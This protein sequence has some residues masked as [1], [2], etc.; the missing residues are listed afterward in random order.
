MSSNTMRHPLEKPGSNRRTALKLLCG[1]AAAT[2]AFMGG[3]SPA[4]AAS[5]SA[6]DTAFFNFALNLKYLQAEFYVRACTGSGVEKHGYAVKGVGPLG[7]VLIKDASQVPFA[8][9]SI[10]QIAV[11]IADD[12]LNHIEFIRGVLGKK[13]VVAR[14]TIDLL[15]SFSTLAQAAGIVAAGVVFD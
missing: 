5:L 7:Q 9:D 1:G 14:P 6:Q 10:K 8:T 11:E 13:R 4:E 15:N 3:S 12:E 2:A